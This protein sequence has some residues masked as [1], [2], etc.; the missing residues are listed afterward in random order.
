MKAIILGATTAIVAVAGLAAPAGATFLGNTGTGQ[1]YV[2]GNASLS[3]SGYSRIGIKDGKIIFEGIS[4]TCTKGNFIVGGMYTAGGQTVNQTT[5]T[6]PSA[7][8]TDC[9]AGEVVNNPPANSVVTIN[10]LC[11]KDA[12]LVKANVSGT[13]VTVIVNSTGACKADTT[14]TPVVTVDPK[15]TDSTVKTASTA[16]NNSDN[17]KAAATNPKGSGATAEL[18]QT[19]A[20]EVI[21]A[22]VATILAGSAYAG[23]MAVRAF[24]ARA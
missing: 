17:S 13:N 6:L 10:G 2:G 18:P 9:N 21:T 19:G 11:D 4:V 5:P 12:A 16:P 8:T 7:D 20:S 24:R 23:T 15:P 14:G 1:G 3:S 22:V